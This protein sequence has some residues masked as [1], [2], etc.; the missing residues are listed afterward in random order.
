MGYVNPYNEIGCGVGFRILGHI[1]YY[2]YVFFVGIS[3]LYNED[4][5]GNTK[6]FG[7]NRI[8]LSLYNAKMLERNLTKVFHV[9][10]DG[11][12]LV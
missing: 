8:F 9:H 4:L 3:V 2:K 10:C 11:T 1:S 7:K 6:I 5:L 12:L